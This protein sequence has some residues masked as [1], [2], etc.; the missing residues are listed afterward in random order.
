MLTFK[1]YL[2]NPSIGVG[3]AADVYKPMASLGSPHQFPPTTNRKYTT[4][5]S[6][7]LGKGHG[8]IKPML[9]AKKLQ[10]SQKIK[11]EISDRL[12]SKVLKRKIDRA[13]TKML[14]KKRLQQP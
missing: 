8:T 14:S 10:T 1:E 4:T 12:K 6:S 7:Y 13:K 3:P 2:G 5:F 9:T 11:N